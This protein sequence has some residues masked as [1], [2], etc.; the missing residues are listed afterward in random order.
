MLLRELEAYNPELLDKPR[1]LAV[2]KRDL[3]DDELEAAIAETLPAGVP[4]LFISAAT[5]YGIDRLKDRLY[6]TVSRTQ[7]L[8]APAQPFED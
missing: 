8:A 5:G 4:Y 6:E 3:I 7:D 2:T 1:L